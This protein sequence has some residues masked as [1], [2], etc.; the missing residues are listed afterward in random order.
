MNS[1]NMA[2]D[3]GTVLITGANGGLGSAFVSQFLK[4]P[5]ASIYTGLFAVRN[6]ATA[7]TLR[8]IVSSSP[9]ASSHEIMALD[10]STLTSVR[11]AAKII[12]ERVAFESLPKIRVLVLNAAIQSHKG[13]DFTKDGLE[14]N[15][16]INYLANFL[17]VLLLLQ[18]MDKEHGRIVIISSWTHDP[19]DARNAHIKLDE[20]KTIF[21]KTVDELAKPTFDE[22]KSMG[23]WELW[24]AGMRRYGMSKTL[25]QMFLY[26]LQRRINSDPELSSISVLSL[27]PGG[28]GTGIARDGPLLLR[29]LLAFILPLFTPLLLLWNHFKP[30]GMLRTPE[31]SA[32][33]LRRACF[34]ESEPL[35]KFPKAVALNGSEV[36]VHQTAEVLDEKKQKELWEGSLKY[37]DLR[38]G[39]TVL[40]N[41]E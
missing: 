6:P 25:M 38:D 2:N 5:E 10:I 27:D 4:S 20:H 7:S 1:S 15:F 31:I 3:Q 19:L 33:D 12:N 16:G 35:G 13:V 9:N 28:M 32:K 41:W 34:D 24:E 11:S 37:A 26:E 14:T 22:E 39:D 36:G 8:S 23:K 21:K 30:N 29:F 40:K 18:S 17:L